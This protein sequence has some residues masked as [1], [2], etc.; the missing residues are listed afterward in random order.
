M[1]FLTDDVLSAAEQQEDLER[2]TGQ[3][4]AAAEEVDFHV[5]FHTFIYERD[6]RLNLVV[7]EASASFDIR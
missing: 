2:D 5:F 6:G 4:F 1:M 7:S 3:I